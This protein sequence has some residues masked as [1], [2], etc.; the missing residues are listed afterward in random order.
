MFA[1]CALEK[2][3]VVSDAMALALDNEG[4]EYDRQVSIVGADGAR[5]VER[6]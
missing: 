4:L 6:G 1:L 3:D 5:V 2:A